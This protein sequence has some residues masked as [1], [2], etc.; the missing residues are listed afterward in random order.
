MSFTRA[1]FAV[2][3]LHAIGNENPHPW[4][5]KYIE[6]WSCVES[7]DP[8]HYALH[9][10]LNAAEPGFGC[11]LLPNWNAIPVRQYPTFEDGVAATTQSLRGAVIHYYPHLLE[12]LRTNNG[13]PLGSQ[14]TPST[15][16]IHELNTWSG[17]ANYAQAIADRANSGDTRADERFPGRYAGQSEI[18]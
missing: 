15:E 3:T 14:G 10:L 5:Q 1:D 17:N 2:A 18:S 6:A 4:L 13:I 9:N 16:I 12:A 11:D 8:G 7:T